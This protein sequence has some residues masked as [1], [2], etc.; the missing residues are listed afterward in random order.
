MKVNPQ[1]LNPQ[2]PAETFVAYA[3]GIGALELVPQG[4]KLKSG[5]VS[6]Y[7]FNS[8]LF[9]T[10]DTLKNLTRAYVAAAN[11]FSFDVVFGPSYKGVPLATAVAIEM[12]GSVGY[13]FNRKE[14]KNH[15]EGGIIVGAGVAGKRV[16]IV[17][18]V[19]TTGGSAGESVEIIRGEGG[20]PVGVVIAFD[21]QERGT[22]T[23]FSAVHV[24]EAKYNIPVRAAA[25]VTDLVRLLERS[26]S[27]EHQQIVASIRIYHDLHG[28]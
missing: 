2:I 9:N 16:L 17:D 25:T 11:E 6:P 27:D 26:D 7:F 3:L 20:T 14:A 21:R 18:D 12:G 5:R 4:R 10:G 28:A 22:E 1:D 23:V 13:S 24:F 8:G 15:G 19:I